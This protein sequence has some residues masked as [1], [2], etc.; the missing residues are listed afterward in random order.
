MLPKISES[1]A[2]I[3]DGVNTSDIIENKLPSLRDVQKLLDI[4]DNKT[5]K[6]A[7]ATRRR[8]ISKK[9]RKSSSESSSESSLDS[10]MSSSEEETSSEECSS[11]RRRKKGKKLK[12][13]LFAKSGNAQLISDEL[14]AHAA[15]DDDIYRQKELKDLSFNLLVAGE[16]EII[17][18]E[19]ISKRERN[20]RLEVL[21]MLAYKHEHLY[22]GRD[23][24][25]ICILCKKSRKRQ[26]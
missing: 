20:T 13:G 7:R 18:S 3:L 6:H 25:S 12:S 22:K 8:K 17:T 1:T 15:L 16:L 10:S 24:Q 5:K 2:Q 21:K 19:K 4:S 23:N 9:K 11:S 26:I 14:F